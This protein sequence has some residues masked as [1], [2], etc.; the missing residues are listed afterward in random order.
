MTIMT[1]VKIIT[2]ITI[3]RITIYFQRRHEGTVKYFG[4]SVGL[5]C[6]RKKEQTQFIP[7]W[8]WKDH[9]GSIVDYNVSSRAFSCTIITIITTTPIIV[10]SKKGC[11]TT[12]FVSEFTAVKETRTQVTPPL[13]LCSITRPKRIYLIHKHGVYVQVLYHNSSANKKKSMLQ[14][15]RRRWRRCM[16]KSNVRCWR[17]ARAWQLITRIFKGS[18]TILSSGITVKQIQSSILW[19]NNSN[20]SNNPNNCNKKHYQLSFQTL[21]I[22]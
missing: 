18:S 20:N 8:I 13:V 1:I 3:I 17:C 16:R 15:G 19:F 5:C 12:I 10:T 11:V 9:K 7:K 2:T 6:S 4:P 22:I 21:T 14:Q